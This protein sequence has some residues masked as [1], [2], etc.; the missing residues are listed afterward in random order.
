MAGGEGSPGDR[1][2]THSKVCVG[3]ARGN[4]MTGVEHMAQSVCRG[5][6]V[7]RGDQ[8]TGGTHGKVC[9][10]G[11]EGRPGGKEELERPVRGVVSSSGLLAARIITVNQTVI[12]CEATHVC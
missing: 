7:A 2:G 3:V 8:V 5:W 12:Y 10:A 11:G 4:Q 9:V 1:G 6:Q